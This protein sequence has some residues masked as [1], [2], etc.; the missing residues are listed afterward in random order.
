[1]N[2]NVYLS[3]SSWRFV[4]ST[5]MLKISTLNAPQTSS[6]ECCVSTHTRFFSRASGSIYII[7]IYTMWECANPHSEHCTLCV[8]FFALV[9]MT[10]LLM[11]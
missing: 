4:T 1:M 11:T 5:A 2:F 8:L 10:I 9:V 6:Y 3:Y 7:C